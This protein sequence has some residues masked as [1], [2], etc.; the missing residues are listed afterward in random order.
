MLQTYI[1]DRT[2]QK[3]NNKK[4]IA[5]DVTFANLCKKHLWKFVKMC[6]TELGYACSYENKDAHFLH[7]AENRTRVI[8]E[9]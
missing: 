2:S 7:V 4:L 6:R 5:L 9:C 1:I 8:I 3:W